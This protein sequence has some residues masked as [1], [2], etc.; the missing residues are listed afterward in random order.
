MPVLHPPQTHVSI[1]LNNLI[2]NKDK[3]QLAF[4][5]CLTC[6]SILKFLQ[7]DNY[8]LFFLMLS[9]G[10]KERGRY[11]H[12]DWWKNIFFS[13]WTHCRPRRLLLRP[14]KWICICRN[15]LMKHI[16]VTQQ[17]NVSRF[18]TTR[19]QDKPKAPINLQKLF[20]FL[21]REQ[22]VTFFP[23]SLKPSSQKSAFPEGIHIVLCCNSVHAT[24][25]NS[26]NS[27]KK[28]INVY[29]QG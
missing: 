12:Q 17:I 6:E 29:S 10:N 9:R 23:R 4:K 8:F 22:I 5:D 3:Q 26:L 14:L 21:P 18:S 7:I 16:K 11:V 25:K 28:V 20:S 24:H 19:P 27:S 15:G 1:Y 13:V 2:W